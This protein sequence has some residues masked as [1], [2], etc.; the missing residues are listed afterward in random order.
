MTFLYYFAFIT[1]TQAVEPHCLSRWRYECSRI[2]PVSPRRRPG[3]DTVAPG[4]FPVYHGIS[5]PS[6]LL[7]VSPDSFKHFKTTGD[8]SRFNTVQHGSSRISKVVHGAATAVTRFIRWRFIPD[9]QPMTQLRRLMVKVT[10]KGHFFALEVCVLLF[11]LPLEGFLFNCSNVH[12]SDMMYTPFTQIHLPSSMSPKSHVLP[13][14]AIFVLFTPSCDDSG[15]SA[16][17]CRY[18]HWTMR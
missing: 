3:G 7:P 10:V 16:H 11:P 6:R 14:M 13:Q 18:S 15:V 9:H 8:M 17:L 5:Q 2:A 1:Y 12:L 4:V